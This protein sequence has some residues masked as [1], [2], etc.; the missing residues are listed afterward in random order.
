MS[1]H[2]GKDARPEDVA[3]QDLSS[4][5]GGSR[6]AAPFVPRTTSLRALTAAAHECRGC[7]L[8]KHAT[9]VVFGEGPKGAHVMLVGEQ[10]GDQE[11]HQGE[12]FVGPAGA[13]LDRAL[14]DAGI[15]RQ[16][17]YVTNAV[18]HFKWEPRGKRRIHKKPRI[19][20]V[21]A[22]RP[23]LEAELKA[24]K[25]AIVVCLGATAAQAVLGSQFKLMAQR[26]R[27]MVSP[28][29]EHVV[30]TIHPSAVLRAPDADARRDAYAM[31]VADLKVVAKALR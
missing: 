7:D 25:P 30:A 17:V 19:S 4:T 24:V 26:G 18:K 15:P 1:I 29:A 20:E 9:Q 12:P 3:E 31:L 6:T 5:P 21:K 22:C 16:D 27:L 2:G 11:D 14:N 13:L 23:W 28:I 10:P 8:Y